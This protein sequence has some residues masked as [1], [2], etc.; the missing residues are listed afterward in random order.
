[1][2][3]A[4]AYS[5]ARIHGKACFGYA[6]IFNNFTKRPITSDSGLAADPVRLGPGVAPSVLL[7]A[8]KRLAVDKV[9]VNTLMRELQE[10]ADAAIAIE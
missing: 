5:I 7:K 4:W 3:S 6:K 10:K 1:M 2:H 9:D 8:P